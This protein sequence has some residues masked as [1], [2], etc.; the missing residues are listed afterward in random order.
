M[1]YVDLAG[2][3]KILKHDAKQQAAVTFMTENYSW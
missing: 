2:A 1:L 3:L